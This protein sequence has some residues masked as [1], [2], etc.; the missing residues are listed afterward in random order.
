MRKLFLALIGAAG[1]AFAKRQQRTKQDAA[2]WRDATG[3]SG[4]K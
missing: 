3:G 1:V 2:L 4:A